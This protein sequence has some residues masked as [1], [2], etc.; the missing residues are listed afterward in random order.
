MVLVVGQLYG[1]PIPGNHPVGIEIVHMLSTCA[2]TPNEVSAYAE[3]SRTCTTVLPR[4]KRTYEVHA[5]A[6]NQC[7]AW[8][9]WGLPYRRH[10]LLSAS[11]RQSL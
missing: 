8:G 5:Q 1:C 9:S 6:K 3:H 10:F 7:W 4:M 2:S 11:R